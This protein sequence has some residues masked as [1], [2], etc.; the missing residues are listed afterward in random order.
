MF[1]MYFVVFKKVHQIILFLWF[2]YQKK[3][4]RIFHFSSDAKK[5]IRFSVVKN[6]WEFGLK[7][8]LILQFKLSFKN[9]QKME[10]LWL[11][12][13]NWVFIYVF[14]KMSTIWIFM[15]VLSKF[16]KWRAVIL[17]SV[18][19]GASIMLETFIMF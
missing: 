17:T 9:S 3:R 14:I 13:N 8:I 5:L 7:T 15:Y 2:S 4:S 6:I 11:F 18:I 16:F 1:L 12:L 19:Y 10:Y